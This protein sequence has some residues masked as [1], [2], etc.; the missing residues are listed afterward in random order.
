MFV[1]INSRIYSK[2]ENWRFP[3]KSGKFKIGDSLPKVGSLKLGNFG[4]LFYLYY[5]DSGRRMKINSMKDGYIEYLSKFDSKVMNTKKGSRSHTRKY[6][7]VVFNIDKFKYFAP[8]TSFK[9]KH[10]KMKDSI[11]IIILG[12]KAAINLTNMI[13][14]PK[15]QLVNYD[16]RSEQD[17]KYSLLVQEEI[18]LI[19]KKE[20]IIKKNSRNLYNAVKRGNPG[21]QKIWCDFSLL[22][23]KSIKYNK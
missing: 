5:M 12:D 10:D 17:I 20:D 9:E 18:K 11:K 15:T 14:V 6:I 19:R 4:C 16:I 23:K 7:G 13:P 2:R 3:T 1:Q 22:E 8:L 21:L